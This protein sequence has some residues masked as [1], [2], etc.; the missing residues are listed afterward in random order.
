MHYD[1]QLGQPEMNKTSNEAIS[2]AAGL[3]LL[4]NL[5]LLRHDDNPLVHAAVW[6]KT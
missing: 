3:L 4:L 5:H 2:K 1:C 6:A